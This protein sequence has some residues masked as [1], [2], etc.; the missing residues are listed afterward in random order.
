MCAHCFW[1]YRDKAIRSR[2]GFSSHLLLVKASSKDDT[3]HC[4]VPVNSMVS[5]GSLWNVF[6]FHVDGIPYLYFDWFA[7]VRKS[8]WSLCS[9]S[10]AVLS[11]N[12]LQ[13]GLQLCFLKWIGINLTTRL[14]MCTLLL[15]L[16][17]QN[18][19]PNSA[20]QSPDGF[21]SHL[22]WVEAWSKLGSHRQT[23]EI[24]DMQGEENDVHNHWNILHNDVQLVLDAN[25]FAFLSRFCFPD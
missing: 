15:T 9:F 3:N 2:D 23:F 18:S 4:L 8:S 12:F 11:I 20:I 24:W 19:H 7:Q 10:C 1:S 25:W 17:R 13:P 22:L 14:H 21:S 16:Q 6:V 5:I